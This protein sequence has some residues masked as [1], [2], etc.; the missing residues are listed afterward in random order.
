MIVTLS[1][2]TP[3]RR[4]STSTSAALALSSNAATVAPAKTSVASAAH[5]FETLGSGRA[6]NVNRSGR[7]A[8]ASRMPR[9]DGGA[10]RRREQGER[11]LERD[12]DLDDDLD[13][14]VVTWVQLPGLRDL[15]LSRLLGDRLAGLEG[16]SCT[17]VDGSKKL[18]DTS[19]RR[20]RDFSLERL[21]SFLR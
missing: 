11:D 17:T 8:L 7:E 13:R 5:V 10:E 21:R 14:G 19:G 9:G 2:G 1:D 3:A 4:A 20:R 15:L 18:D 12:L 6:V 16:R